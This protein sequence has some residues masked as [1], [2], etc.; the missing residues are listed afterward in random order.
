MQLH[1]K[2]I[3]DMLSA[4][5][6]TQKPASPKKEVKKEPAQNSSTASS[7]SVIAS[8]STHATSSATSSHASSTATSTAP[9][10]GTNSTPQQN[11]SA[12]SQTASG[13]SA[14]A[15]NQSSVSASTMTTHI[16]NG[17]SGANVYA[18][19]IALSPLG[20]VQLLLLAAVLGVVGALFVEGSVLSGAYAWLSRIVGVK[21]SVPD[22]SHV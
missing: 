7:T 9:V 4:H 22:V 13:N 19:T 18:N 11:S 1:L 12:P 5:K 2:E 8:T 21:S 15:S 17:S 16:I 20:T 10:L 3:K 6:T 14:K